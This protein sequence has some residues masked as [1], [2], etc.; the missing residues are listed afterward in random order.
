MF[1]GKRKI[2][3]GIKKAKNIENF[4][5]TI[6]NT[7]DQISKE[8]LNHDY[9]EAYRILEEERKK[10]KKFLKRVFDIK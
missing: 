5:I 10:S 1:K 9:T 3:I 8:N 7:G 6:F 4:V 2:R